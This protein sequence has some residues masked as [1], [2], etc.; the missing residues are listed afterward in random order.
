MKRLS[1][2]LGSFIL[3]M[4][5]F[6]SCKKDD[7]PTYINQPTQP[8]D[9]T[10]NSDPV[11]GLK[12]LTASAGYDRILE[13]PGNETMLEGAYWYSDNRRLSNDVTA[14]WSKLSGP[15]SYT[16]ENKDSLLT[17]LS[18][19]EEGVYSF[20]LTLTDVRFAKSDKDTT[21][22]TVRK[23]SSI[24]KEIIFKDINMICPW[25]CGWE[26]QKIYNH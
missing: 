11:N 14:R 24:P 6:N 25:Y 3:I 22:V 7:Q 2:L 19:L 18:N 17:K 10:R 15:D 26:I 5:T 8:A 23:S 20:E 9:S 4:E 13:L 1:L 12:W 16:L 21:I